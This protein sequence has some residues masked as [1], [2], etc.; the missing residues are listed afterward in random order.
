MWIFR[1]HSQGLKGG[2]LRLTKDDLARVSWRVVIPDSIG[3][4]MAGQ[5]A[6]PT[7]SRETP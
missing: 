3:R 1:F 6:S 2:E 5:G 7:P 4:R